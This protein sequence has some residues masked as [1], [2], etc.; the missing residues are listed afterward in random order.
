MSNVSLAIELIKTSKK[1]LKT[2]SAETGCSVYMLKKY[3]KDFN[4][5]LGI[6]LT[7]LDLLLHDKTKTQ[8]QIA[9]LCN[10]SQST[11]HRRYL[12]LHGKKTSSAVIEL[13]KE[14]LSVETNRHRTC[15]ELSKLNP[16]VSRQAF[17]RAKKLLGIEI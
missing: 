13:A 4:V 12:K 17:S 10:C 14:I 9:A 16:R 11:V 8:K 6:D 1:S 2:I 5:K 15:V 3:R 7:L